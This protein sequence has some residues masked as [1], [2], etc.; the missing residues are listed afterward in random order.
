MNLEG[1]QGNHSTLINAL[2]I[3]NLSMLEPVEAKEII[4][5]LISVINDN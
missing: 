5:R 3:C 4:N 2:S 1:K